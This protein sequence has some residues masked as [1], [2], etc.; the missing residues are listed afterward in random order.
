MPE[1][2]CPKCNQAQF[3]VM[4]KD[5]LKQNNQCWRCDKEE[6]AKGS[7]STEEFERRERQAAQSEE[8]SN[9]NHTAL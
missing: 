8:K 4:D 9:G 2:I 7:L 6:W 3:S 1:N 5:Y